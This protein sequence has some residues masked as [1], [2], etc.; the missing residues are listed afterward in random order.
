MR[1][2]PAI[3]VDDPARD[4][5]AFPE[6]LAGV[7]ARQIIVGLAKRQ[8]PVHRRC[9]IAEVLR[10]PDE[11]LLGARRTVDVYGG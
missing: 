5:D 3:L 11:R 7:L 9:Q 2:R 6:R 4:D 10:Q 1:H 8:I